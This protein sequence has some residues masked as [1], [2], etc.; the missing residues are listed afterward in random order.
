[1]TNL[2]WNSLCHCLGNLSLFPVCLSSPDEALSVPHVECPQTC[3][4][5]TDSH[6]Q[7]ATVTARA[8]LT[9]A[10]SWTATELTIPLT[11][12]PTINIE[13]KDVAVTRNNPL[14]FANMPSHKA[15][16]VC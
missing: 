9:A 1:M 3:T 12:A 5:Y 11:A 14:T 6:T 7:L 4:E 2:K 13:I 16:A 8:A 10:P 15:T